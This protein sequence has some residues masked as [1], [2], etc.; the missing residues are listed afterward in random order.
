MSACTGAGCTGFSYLC[1]TNIEGL[2]TTIPG[3]V[4]QDGNPMSSLGNGTW[5]V[6]YETCTQYCSFSDIPIVC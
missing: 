4:D 5:G 1:K 3:L 2:G 6:T